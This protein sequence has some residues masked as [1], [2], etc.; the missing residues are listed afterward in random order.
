MQGRQGRRESEG[1]ISVTRPLHGRYMAVTWP[2]RA[3]EKV[4]EIASIRSLHDRYMAVIRPLR[5]CEKVS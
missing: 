1:R 2:W 3:C 4:S 5:A